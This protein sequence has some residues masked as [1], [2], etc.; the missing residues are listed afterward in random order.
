MGIIRNTSLI[1]LPQG[2]SGMYNL[3][4]G[5]DPDDP[6]STGSLGI[7][8]LT[9]TK[10][11]FAELSTEIADAKIIYYGIHHD[12]S[13]TMY[14]KGQVFN[15]LQ[16]QNFNLYNHDNSEVFA[17]IIRP[18]GVSDMFN[19]T[20]GKR[21]SNNII[22]H[23]EIVNQANWT[24]EVKYVSYN[25]H[26]DINNNRTA[27][28]S[29]PAPT[30]APVTTTNVSSTA[31]ATSTSP[32][33]TIELLKQSDNYP[34]PEL[35]AS[36]DNTTNPVPNTGVII[37]TPLLDSLLEGDEFERNVPGSSNYIPYSPP[38]SVSDLGIGGFA[39]FQ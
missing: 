19:G 20:I 35:G 6:K 14:S 28:A 33:P 26:Y 29:T 31:T 16:K 10:Y 1:H 3:K 7:N 38:A 18:T 11:G 30:P 32:P 24:S 21:S 37:D 5:V 34:L 15:P 9:D 13:L 12:P 4:F 23:D 17:S 2:A 39:G 36:A 27:P 22:P 8:L 25:W